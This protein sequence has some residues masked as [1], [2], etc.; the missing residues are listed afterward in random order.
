MEPYKT[1]ARRTG[2]KQNRAGVVTAT[3][4]LHHTTSDSERPCLIFFC[5]KRC[6]LVTYWW[7]E[8]DG[9]CNERVRWILP[10]LLAGRYWVRW[11]YSNR[12]STVL[13]AEN[14]RPRMSGFLIPIQTDSTFASS[15]ATA[16]LASFSFTKGHQVSSQSHS[17]TSRYF[18][19][20]LDGISCSLQQLQVG[21]L[22]WMAAGLGQTQVSHNSTRSP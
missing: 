2:A 14:R 4:T 16:L 13:I 10:A 21:K 7:Y 12:T 8:R 17:I 3:I 6:Y 1:T 22:W 9:G 18:I 15:H 5:S 19:V 11:R 20:T